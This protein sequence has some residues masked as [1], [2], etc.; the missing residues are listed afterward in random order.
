MTWD[1]DLPRK[2]PLA[3][4]RAIASLPAHIACSAFLTLDG[5]AV[6]TRHIDL[7]DRLEGEKHTMTLELSSSP[8]HVLYDD[9]YDQGDGTTAFMTFVGWVTG[10]IPNTYLRNPFSREEIARMET[11]WQPVLEALVFQERAQGW[12]V[13]FDAV[14]VGWIRP[15]RDG[16]FEWQF[17]GRTSRATTVDEAEAHLKSAWA[18]SIYELARA[19]A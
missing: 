17:G 9:T 1:D 3:S 19:Q 11:R 7:S 6:V 13:S 12:T 8:Y 2:R 14:E 15:E 5:K 18:R 4:R 16:G 10:A